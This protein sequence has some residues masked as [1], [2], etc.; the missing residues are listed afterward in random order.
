MMPF[1]LAPVY[2]PYV[3]GGNKLI[4]QYG[5]RTELP[6]LAESWEL[7]AH[8][9]GDCAVATG[10]YAGT[11]FSKLVA[12]HP[13]ITGGMREFP[14][15]IKLIDAKQRLSVQVHPDDAYARRNGQRYG[16]TEMW[17]VLEAEPG[18]ALYCGFQRQLSPAEFQRRIRDGSL[19]AV[20][21]RRPAQKGDTVFVPAGTIHAI[22]E[23]L[24]IAEI[25]QSSDATYR[26]YDYGRPDASGNPRELHIRNALDV[27]RLEP[28][29]CAAPGSRLLAQSPQLRLK[30]L[31]QCPY[32]TVDRLDLNGRCGLE[33]AGETFVS[34]LC[35]DGS[36]MLSCRDQSFGLNKGDSIFIPAD[37]PA[38]TLSG[39]GVFL[40]TFV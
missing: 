13:E 32:F 39:E 7:S 18:A 37:S 19:M 9:G 6:V 15:L 31:A 3:W 2:K 23:G 22:G 25:Q 33:T 27:T 16:K 36:A 20:L 11:T 14:I 8:P 28:A 17:V 38:C 5:K 26:V 21:G 29:C 34:L 4:T 30:R 12:G 24:L 40:K 10:P 1:R 35:V